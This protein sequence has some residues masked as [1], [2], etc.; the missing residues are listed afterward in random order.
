MRLS[1]LLTFI[2]IINATA[3]VYSQTVKIDLELRN[4]TLQQVFQS[5]QE[6]TDYDFFY[7]NEH[8]PQSIV[9][10]KSYKNSRVNEILDEVLEG[11]D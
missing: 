11:T 8:L 5:I 1:V 4:A 6:Q 7:K 10:N 3:S 9:I 2:A